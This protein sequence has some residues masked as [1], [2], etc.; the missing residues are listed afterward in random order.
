L[1]NLIDSPGHVDFTGE[2]STAVRL[3]DGAIVVVDVIEGI[4]SQTK[5]TLRQAW[6]ERIK[7]ILVLNKIDR[8]IT[9]K[10]LTP[11]DAY[12]HLQQLLEKINAFVGELFTTDVFLDLNKQALIEE[13]MNDANEQSKQLGSDWY[14][15]LDDK[16][17]S[18]LYFQPEKDNV[19]FASAIDGWAFNISSFSNCLAKK[20]GIS[21]RTL[22][23]TLWGDY[24][25]NFKAKK[26]LKGAQAKAKKN[27]FVSMVLENVWSV[28]EHVLERKDSLMTEKIV[29]S[30]GITLNRR[31]LNSTDAKLRLQSIFAQW[32]P[33]SDNV[34]NS[35]CKLLPSPVELT[36][37]RTERLMCS[38]FNRFDGLPMQTKQLKQSFLQCSADDQAVKIACV[39]KMFAVDRETLPEFKFRS[40][41]LEEIA[42]RREAIKPAA[43]VAPSITDLTLKSEANASD[44]A[45]LSQEELDRQKKDETI[46]Q[47]K[48][49][50]QSDPKSTFIAFARV[51]SGS[52]KKGDRIYVLGPKHDPRKLIGNSVVTA[53]KLTELAAD[54]HITTAV[55]EG[56][57]M[58]M[59][60]EL[61]TMEKAV[62]GNIVG[63]RGLDEHVLKT[64]TLSDNQYCPAFV[65]LHVAAQAILRVALEP[66][67]P[68]E[69]PQLVRGLRLL[70][71]ADPCVEVRLQTSGEHVIVTT[72]E[73]HLQRCV[74]D[75]VERF[76]GIEINV[77]EPIVPFRETIVLKPKMDMV[78]EL[79][80]SSQNVKNSAKSTATAAQAIEMNTP[81]KRSSIE[82]E[83]VPLPESVVKTLDHNQD[84]LKLVS[85]AY[86]GKLDLNLIADYDQK[87]AQLRIELAEAFQADQGRL[88]PEN[89][90]D[91]IWAVGPNYSGANVLFNMIPE[92]TQKFSIWQP[93]K[94]S[95]ESDQLSS[96]EDLARI[97]YDTSFISG[98]Q[99][100]TQAGPLCEEPL[101][102]VAF[103][104]KQWSIDKDLMC[105]IEHD[106]YGPFSGQIMS[107]VK[108]GCRKAFQQQPQRLLSP[109]FSSN[110]QVSA[111][112]LGKMYGVICKRHGRILSEEMQEGSQTFVVN[113]ILPVIESFQF[114]NEIRK[115][116][117]GMA[118]PQLLFSHWEVSDPSS[119]LNLNLKSSNLLN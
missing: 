6:I 41:T 90:I 92:S 83:A 87:V 49:D 46:E 84:I 97:N 58:L 59:G 21:E 86:G 62:A 119:S 17:D 93:F 103:L 104:I 99:L 33:L 13:G 91:L 56:I 31:E 10:K 27:L 108:E 70:N 68:T 114:A 107:T 1:I 57:Y 40:L 2:V 116:T 29:A 8:L 112:V 75:L 81:N 118:I 44:F 7:P 77:S 79:I 16:D 5:A 94:R 65:D 12:T 64:A 39:S 111:D 9:E 15:G 25:I 85:N 55:I 74:D 117:S 48:S 113:A 66:Q 47:E 88:W 105:N 60:R 50:D 101:M 22:N 4:C 51:F 52:F 78:N 43:K 80:D 42:Q 76:A 106:P 54:Q 73:V 3:S 72:G 67:N 36:E 95:P 89:V 69:M 100:A 115:Q 96:A 20:L 110:I 109:M 18:N 28:Y 11:I 30:L 35:V 53:T 38:N 26:I 102:G 98:F 24:Y 14:V 63:L 23:R 34:L 32:L 61:E 37:E 45:Y 71:Q 19:V 82:F